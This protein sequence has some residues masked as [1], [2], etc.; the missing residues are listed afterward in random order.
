MVQE[1]AKMST[2]GMKGL[3]KS[4]KVEKTH[5]GTYTGGKV[6]ISKDGTRMACL[7]H[8][9]VAFLDALTGE[10]QFTLQE[11]VRE[12]LQEEIVTFAL[13]PNHAQIVT[14]SKN[15]LI[16]LWDIETQKCLKTIKVS[17][18]GSAFHINVH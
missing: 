16:R 4:W 17:V 12:D 1:Y 7:F 13:R 18:V 9:D 14:A 6:E 2:K 11:H 3:S 15:L 10:M 5:Q 8:D